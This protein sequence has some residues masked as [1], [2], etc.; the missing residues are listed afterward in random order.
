MINIP[1]RRI[2]NQVFNPVWPGIL[3]FAVFVLLLPSILLADQGLPDGFVYLDEIIPSI[4]LDMRYCT[5]NNFTGKPVDGYLKP[6][7]IISRPAAAALKEVQDELLPFGLSLKVY[8]AYRPQMA[9]NDFIRWA[10]D[11][12]DE[13]T[14]AQYYPDVDKANLFKDGYIARKSGHT[15]GSTVDLTIVILP[16]CNELDMGSSFDFLGPVSWPDSRLV[17]SEKRAHRLLLRTLM[18]KHGFNPYSKE[19]WHFSLAN[20]P[21]PD[22]YFNFPVQ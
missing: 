17:T 21:Y 1:L 3:W 12:N 8:D 13:K 19:W 5:A 7:C 4:K 6:R 18:I 15:R 11:V 14:K 16:D 9:V 20:E 10:A 2:K 22:K